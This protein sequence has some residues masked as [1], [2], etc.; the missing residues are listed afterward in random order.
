MTCKS[1][2]DSRKHDSD[3]NHIQELCVGSISELDHVGSLHQLTR[4]VEI[5]ITNQRLSVS[6]MNYDRAR[7]QQQGV[8]TPTYRGVVEGRES[9]LANANSVLSS[10]VWLDP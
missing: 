3:N 5:L 6:R 8:M 2:S 1:T 7:H 9:Y 4:Q 10:I